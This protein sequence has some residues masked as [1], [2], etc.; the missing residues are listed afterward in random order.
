MLSG[1]KGGHGWHTCYM[2]LRGGELL[3]Y[4]DARASESGHSIG[5]LLLA[6]AKMSANSKKK[7]VLS[8]EG[9]DNSE[10]RLDFP[11]LD[12]YRKWIPTLALMTGTDPEVRR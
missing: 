1:K 3:F 10:V 9:I 12:V 6:G 4:R 8:L 7:G 11:D 5:S 2:V